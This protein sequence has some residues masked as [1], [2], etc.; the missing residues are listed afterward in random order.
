[1]PGGIL[2]SVPRTGS[3][4]DAGRPADPELHTV[5]WFWGLSRVSP[6]WVASVSAQRLPTPGAGEW[7]AVVMDSG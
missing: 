2:S 7:G 6:G 5:P 3:G 4:W 1:M